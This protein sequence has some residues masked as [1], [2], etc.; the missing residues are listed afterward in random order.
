MTNGNGA[1]VVLV[2]AIVKGVISIVLVCTVC[3]CLVSN[4]PIPD[5]VVEIVFGALAV[6]FGLSATMYRRSA[7]EIKVRH[8]RWKRG[9]GI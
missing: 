9:G 7:E 2:M 5:R 3:Y 4:L 8:E 1:G 6:Y